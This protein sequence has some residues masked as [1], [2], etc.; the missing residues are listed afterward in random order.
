VYDD[1]DDVVDDDDVKCRGLVLLNSSGSWRERSV[2]ISFYIYLLNTH[3]VQ[4]RT[5]KNT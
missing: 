3:N 4:H 2:I 5:H 1:D